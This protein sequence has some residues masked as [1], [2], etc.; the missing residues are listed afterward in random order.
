MLG[1]TPIVIYTL[2]HKKVTKSA[3]VLAV[4]MWLAL[5]G[6]LY[7]FTNIILFNS[8]HFDQVRSLTIIECVYFMTQVITTVGYGDITPAYPRGQVFVGA[9]VTL[10]FFVIALLMAEM[11]EIVMDTVL[12]YKQNLEHRL[13]ER[14]RLR[15]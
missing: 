2:G 3:L 15:R 5:F 9:Y 10:S 14:L 13:G 7:L 6:G 8:P 12:K 11:Q 1:S 4:L